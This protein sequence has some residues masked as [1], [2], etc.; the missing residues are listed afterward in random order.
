M[1]KYVIKQPQ[2]TVNCRIQ[3]MGTW[4]S[5]EQFFQILSMFEKFYNEI[6]QKR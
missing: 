1:D 4:V 5:N 2:Q 3:G 6:M